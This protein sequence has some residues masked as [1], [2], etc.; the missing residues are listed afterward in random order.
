MG[1]RPPSPV[2]PT[3]QNVDFAG[4]QQRG[5]PNPVRGASS[6]HHMA[7][8]GPSIR[9]STHL[10]PSNSRAARAR[11]FGGP[12]GGLLSGLRRRKSRN[13]QLEP[14][15]ARPCPTR[16]SKVR[17]IRGPRSSS[18]QATAFAPMIRAANQGHLRAPG[19]FSFLGEMEPL[20]PSPVSQLPGPKI[21]PS[22]PSHPPAACRDGPSWEE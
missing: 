22:F 9:N 4:I 6:Q 19:A 21:E 16:Q 8:C 17:A 11:T 18:S 2:S 1:G 13:R 14:A 10:W 20:L 5:P 12:A 7:S 15:R 3:Q